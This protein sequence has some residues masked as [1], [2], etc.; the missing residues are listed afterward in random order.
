[1]N[2]RLDTFKSYETHAWFSR[3]YKRLKSED[4]AFCLAFI[5]DNEAL[6]AREFEHKV[7]RLYMGVVPPK[8]W[9]EISELL[10]CCA[11]KK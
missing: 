9:K 2:K 7:H 3:V 6:D 5:A 11:S 4:I 8:R 10:V 1:M